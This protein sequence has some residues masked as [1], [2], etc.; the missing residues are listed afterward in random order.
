[1]CFRNISVVTCELLQVIK[2]WIH[3]FI[4]ELDRSGLDQSSKLVS[5][6]V[7]MC[8]AHRVYE[9]VING[10]HCITLLKMM[11]LQSS[12]ENYDFLTSLMKEDSR[13]V[14]NHMS[15]SLRKVQSIHFIHVPMHFNMYSKIAI[16]PICFCVSFRQ[17]VTTALTAVFYRAN[18]S[19]IKEEEDVIH[20]LK[21]YPLLHLLRGDCAP[22]EQTIV[23]PSA[24]K[25][26][27]LTHALRST[28]HMMCYKKGLIIYLVLYVKFNAFQYLGL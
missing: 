12:G 24:I 23:R 7:V 15:I 2:E 22:G 8:F 6:V 10:N 16:T 20:L 27:D 25:W 17:L 1:M 11:A 28:S 19:N 4:R 18:S 13:C 9:Y 26:G 21:A 3:T 14:S 5:A